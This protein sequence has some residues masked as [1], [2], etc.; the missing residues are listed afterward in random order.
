MEE[1]YETSEEFLSDLKS[2][3]LSYDTIQTSIR[4]EL[5]V[6]AVMDRVTSH[7]NDVDEAEVIDFYQKNM[8]KFQS[9]EKR[10]TRHILITIN[11]DYA[12]NKRPAVEKRLDSLLEQLKDGAD[13]TR[14]AAENSEC[15]TAMNGGEV[16]TVTKG[17]LYPEI[18]DVLFMMNEGDFA[19]PIETEVG[20]HIIKCEGIEPSGQVSLFEAKE[21]IV[22]Y[23][24]DKKRTHAQRQWLRQFETK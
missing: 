22:A 3:G 9:S 4:R 10:T 8:D 15:P 14:L 2:N 17:Q 20:F 16:G 19:G 1:R 6:E 5:W 21:Q 7:I 13:F 11:D 23:L 18:D 12:E 24:L